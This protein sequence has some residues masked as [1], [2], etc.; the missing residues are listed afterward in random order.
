M[1]QNRTCSAREH[2]DSA[3]GLER[4]A[5]SA[6]AN[7]VFGLASSSYRRRRGVRGGALAIRKLRAPG[8]VNTKCVVA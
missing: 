7:G 1:Q 6:A 3:Q 2:G 4:R 8:L 5:A